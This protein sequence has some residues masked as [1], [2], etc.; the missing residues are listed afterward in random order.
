MWPW[1]HCIGLIRVFTEARPSWTQAMPAQFRMLEELGQAYA[2]TSW[3]AAAVFL[4]IAGSHHGTLGSIEVG[5]NGNTQP[6]TFLACH[7]TF[8]RSRVPAGRRAPCEPSFSISHGPKR[9]EISASS[10]RN[11]NTKSMPGQLSSSRCRSFI[12]FRFTPT[13]AA[14][15]LLP[16]PAARRCRWHCF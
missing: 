12:L 7:V 9:P 13:A 3:E 15:R 8:L 11:N 10:R 16:K 1:I 4:F 2:Y 5:K 14:R 6:T